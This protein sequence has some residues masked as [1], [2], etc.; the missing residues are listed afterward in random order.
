MGIRTIFPEDFKKMS[1][2]RAILLARVA[3]NGTFE[4]LKEIFGWGLG[5]ESD[6]SL[7]CT[8][9]TQSQS[10]PSPGQLAGTQCPV[11]AKEHRDWASAQSSP[12]LLAPWPPPIPL[13]P[14]GQDSTSICAECAHWAHIDVTRPLECGARMLVLEKTPQT[15][16]GPFWMSAEI[17][18]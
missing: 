3:P 18:S 9:G 13:P 1:C 7:S 17:L 16:H 8:Q 12:A 5:T 10:R 15:R 2:R 4:G 14:I 6:W 11:L